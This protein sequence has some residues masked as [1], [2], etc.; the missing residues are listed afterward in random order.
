MDLG[1]FLGQIDRK[2]GNKKA[3]KK[4]RSIYEAFLP[5]KVT[6]AISDAIPTNAPQTAGTQTNARTS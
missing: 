6:S 3:E 1:K 4:A 2:L 5:F